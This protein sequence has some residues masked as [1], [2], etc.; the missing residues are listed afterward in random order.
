MFALDA[1]D[2]SFKFMSGSK[3]PLAIHTSAPD[4]AA[5]IDKAGDLRLA[6]FSNDVG[7]AGRPAIVFQRA[8]N[9]EGTP[10]IVN[11]DDIVGEVRFDAFNGE[12]FASTAS[13]AVKVDG[14]PKEGKIGTSLG[15]KT[16][17]KDGPQ[18]GKVVEWMTLGSDGS[19]LLKGLSENTFTVNGGASVGKDLHVDG[20]FESKG[21]SIAGDASIARALSVGQGISV[22]AGNL[23]VQKGG[24]VISG[25]DGL[26]V[27]GG[28]ISAK[29]KVDAGGDISTE[30]A[31]HA[32]GSAEI[33]G[34]FRILSDKSDA[35]AIPSGGLTVAK[36]ITATEGDLDIKKGGARI[37]GNVDLGG[38]LKRKGVNV[39]GKLVIDDASD[40]S[41]T[42]AGGLVVKKSISLI[43]RIF[44]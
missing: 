27:D 5:T 44:I 33:K 18:V 26:V 39:G 17:A 37:A 7:D 16:S 15:F 13:I 20:A 38:G 10:Q 34:S 21:A 19:L 12:K 43:F 30:G 11:K 32:K 29:G 31:I 42:F 28:D 3:A 22:E 35:V 36:A 41:A 1:S 14:A 40:D 23:V 25:S 24:A 2:S 9:A 8:R 6:T 4:G